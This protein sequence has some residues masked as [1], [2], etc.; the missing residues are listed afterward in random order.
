MFWLEIPVLGIVLAL[1]LIVTILLAYAWVVRALVYNDGPAYAATRRA[2]MYRTIRREMA[3][4]D[5]RYEQLLRAD[6]PVGRP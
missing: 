1:L 3:D 4:L 5:R 6:P 2:R